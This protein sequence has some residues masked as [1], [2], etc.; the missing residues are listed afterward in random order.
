LASVSGGITTTVV[1]GKVTPWFLG[2]PVQLTQVLPQDTGSLAS[3]IM[4]LFG[5]MSLAA[6]IGD[7]RQVTLARSLSTYFPTDQ[8]AIRGTE[9]VAINVHDLG[10]NTTAGPLV[11]L[12]G[13]A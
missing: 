4:L 8:V 12:V 5:D 6:A 2:F 10:D 3:K 9:R 11:G 13:T 1:D 7:R